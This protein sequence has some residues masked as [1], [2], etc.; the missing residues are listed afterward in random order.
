MNRG[1]AVN[2]YLYSS[3]KARIVEFV[4]KMGLMA[5]VALRGSLEAF[6]A[7]DGALA[8]KIVAGDDEIDAMEKEIDLECLRSIAMRQPVREELRFIFAVLKTITD[9]ERIGDESVN[10]A[11][12]VLELKKYPHVPVNPTLL[13]MRDIAE[14]MLR[15]ALTAFQTS[16]GDMCAEISC[17]DEQLD[18][19]YASVY[20]E[21]VDGVDAFGTGD[22]GLL[23]AA[24]GQM[25]IARHLE[26]IGDHVTNV[27][28]RVYFMD[29]GEI[30]QPDQKP[31]YAHP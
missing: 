1:G 27:A 8:E 12:W 26:R 6:I 7:E 19:M 10:I 4:M 28:E 16:N 29:K 31:V 30:L 11:R 5:E 14:G 24:A 18:R 2:S 22:R 23:R 17:R 3:D 20:D 9:L 25:W 15:D 13:D 21:L